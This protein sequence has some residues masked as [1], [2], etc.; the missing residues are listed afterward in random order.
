MKILQI[1]EV[2]ELNRILG[3]VESLTV[4]GNGCS[5]SDVKDLCNTINFSG[6]L[7]DY[8]RIIQICKKAQLLKWKQ[9]QLTLTSKGTEFLEKNPKRYFE[10]S[11]RQ[12]EYIIENWLFSGIWKKD[13][14]KLFLRF[15]P[16]YKKVTYEIDINTSLLPPNH[17]ACFALM[18]YLKIINNETGGIY[19]VN[20]SYVADVKEL[21]SSNGK[22]LSELERS[23]S[24][25]Q[26]LGSAAENLVVQYEKSRLITQ[27]L[28]AEANLVR[29]ISDLNTSAGY[30]IE[31]YTNQHTM[32]YDRFIEVKSSR[33]SK[34]RFYWTQNEYEIAKALGDHYWIYFVGDFS[35]TT[36]IDQIKP[37]I[38]QN[39]VKSLF[40]SSL[41]L[42]TDSNVDG[43]SI[44]VN[45]FLV[46]AKQN[47]KLKY[48]KWENLEAYLL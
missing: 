33:Q 29:K 17:S 26:R 8:W 11:K 28:L 24:E 42:T 34:L 44:S 45:V 31:S 41:D 32:N 30:D 43:V 39:P 47:L 22:S 38:I 16:N 27:G 20:A 2:D 40:I 25:N 19:R 6:R 48:V 10:S 46:E 3:A 1:S 36:K 23:L 35:E 13:L 15:S 9:K 21:L 5:V 37:I 4:D 14:R 12:I 18:R 7:P